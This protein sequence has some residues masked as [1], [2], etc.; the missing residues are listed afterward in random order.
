MIQDNNDHFDWDWLDGATPTRDSGPLAGKDGDPSDVN[1]VRREGY[2]YIE[3]SSPRR[4]DDL[5]R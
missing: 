1:N 3:S 5:A 4:V 2:I